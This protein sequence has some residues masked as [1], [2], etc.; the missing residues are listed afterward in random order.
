[1]SIALA[2][3]LSAP[4]SL[5]E[6]WGQ[7]RMAVVPADAPEVQVTEM[8]RAFYAGA[9]GLQGLMFARLDDQTDDCTAEDEAFM[10][11]INAELEAFAKAI[12]G[13]EA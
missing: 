2:F 11:G 13:G 6:A 1:M 7:F 3:K 5:A 9:A 4:R 12:A 10:M 8:R